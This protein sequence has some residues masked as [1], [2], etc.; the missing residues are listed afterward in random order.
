M[1]QALRKYLPGG[2]FEDVSP[3]RSRAM[4]SVKDRGNKTTERRLRLGLVRGG[5]RG[6]KVRPKGLRGNPDFLFPDAHVAIFVDGCFWHGCPDCG[7]VPRTNTT[8]WAAKIERNRQRDRTIVEQLEAKGFRVLRFWEHEL[9]DQLGI[10]IATVKST[11]QNSA[12]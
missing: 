5:V 8:F 3:S 7:H 1:E 6:W 10:C 12:Y 9:R 4:A 11:V 2:V